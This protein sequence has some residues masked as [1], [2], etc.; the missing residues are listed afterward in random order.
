MNHQL[1][2]D[3]KYSV[4]VGDITVYLDSFEISGEKKFSFQPM[5][6]SGIK[7]GELGRHPAILKIKGRILKSDGNNPAVKLNSDM[8][9]N[10]RYFLS[11]G[12]L[13]FNAARLKKFRIVSDTDSQFTVCELEFYCDSY[14]SQGESN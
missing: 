2:S 14:I 7:F 8:T 6:S 11:I 1:V 13:Y 9:N 12:T 4:A 10:V 5:A 3:Q